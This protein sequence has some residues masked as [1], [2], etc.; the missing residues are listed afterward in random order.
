M[1]KFLQSISTKLSGWDERY[2]T[3]KEENSNWLS[4]PYNWDVVVSTDRKRLYWHN[5]GFSGDEYVS[6]HIYQIFDYVL[7]WYAVLTKQVQ[8]LIR[9]NY[10]NNKKLRTEN[11]FMIKGWEVFVDWI[12]KLYNDPKNYRKEKTLE[13]EIKKWE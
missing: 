7:N 6:T 8:Y 10:L 4:L 12:Y 11:Q 5:D 2:V 1:F 9:K 13:D 3:E